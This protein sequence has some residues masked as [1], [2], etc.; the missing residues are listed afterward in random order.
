[1]QSLSEDSLAETALRY[2]KNEKEIAA[3]KEA[4]TTSDL[5]EAEKNS[6][7]DML[8]AGGARTMLFMK[9]KSSGSI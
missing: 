4:V 5:P 9:K 7:I 6:I 8:E 3:L 1:V 2:L